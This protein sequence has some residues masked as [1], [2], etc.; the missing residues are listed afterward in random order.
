MTTYISPKKKYI[1]ISVSRQHIWVCPCL[2]ILGNYLMQWRYVSRLSQFTTYES[3]NLWEAECI[4]IY[5]YIVATWNTYSMILAHASIPR[6]NLVC[7][8]YLVTKT[9]KNKDNNTL[10][11]SEPAHCFF[12]PPKGMKCFDMTFAL[13]SYKSCYITKKII[14]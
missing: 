12:P 6:K 3:C 11:Y 7:Y 8:L 2:M 10:L 13:T 5:I 14:R 1:Y 4:Y 9:W